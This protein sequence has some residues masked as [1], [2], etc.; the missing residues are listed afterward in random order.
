LLFGSQNA[1][2]QSVDALQLPPSAVSPDPLVQVVKMSLIVSTAYQQYPFVHSLELRHVS[3]Q[4]LLKQRSLLHDE[5]FEQLP[6]PVPLLC[7]VQCGVTWVS[8]VRPGNVPI[9]QAPPPHSPLSKTEQH[10]SWQMDEEQS[11]ERQFASAP[12]LLP[13][14]VVPSVVD[15]LSAMGATQ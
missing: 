10:V 5:S 6:V 12:Q 13:P 4:L 15:R 7:V 11:P 2:R 14:S 8:K 3:T 1:V 9:R